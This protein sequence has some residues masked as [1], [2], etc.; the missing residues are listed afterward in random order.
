[1]SKT[2]QMIKQMQMTRRLWV[3]LKI[4]SC[5]RA[6]QQ[7]V[8][9]SVAVSEKVQTVAITK[10]RSVTAPHANVTYLQTSTLANAR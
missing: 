9:Q 3:F 6:M 7:P 10:C 2:M 8:Q 4:V 1:M 5:A